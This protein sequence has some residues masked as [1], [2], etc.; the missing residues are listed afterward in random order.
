[1]EP[2][3]EEATGMADADTPGVTDRDRDRTDRTESGD[4]EGVT[5]MLP[6]KQK[7]TH[8]TCNRCNRVVY[9]NDLFTFIPV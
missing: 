1:M 2:A 7:T 6:V 4:M 8:T 5:T 9:N 3:V